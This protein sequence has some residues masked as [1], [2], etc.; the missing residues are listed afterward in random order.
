MEDCFH[1]VENKWKLL[2]QKIQNA[3]IGESVKELEK[4]VKELEESGLPEEQY[5]EIYG[6]AKTELK[7][8]PVKEG[9]FN[10]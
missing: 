10:A 1:F 6:K 9:K 4:A 7:A 8:K 5:Q 3:I 2:K